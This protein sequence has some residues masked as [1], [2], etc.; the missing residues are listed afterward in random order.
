MNFPLV[1]YGQ[2][3]DAPVE[4]P[5]NGKGHGRWTITF[6][7]SRVPVAAPPPYHDP[8]LAHDEPGIALAHARFIA[9]AAA[10]SVTRRLRA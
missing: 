1:A 5:S 2:L 7:A 10:R 9:R 8:L 3:T 6:K 4:P